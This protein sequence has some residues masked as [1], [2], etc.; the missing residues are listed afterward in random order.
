LKFK[1][2]AKRPGTSRREHDYNL[3]QAIGEYDYTLRAALANPAGQWFAAQIHTQ[4]AIVLDALGR[5]ADAAK[6]RELARATSR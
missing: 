3:A 6:D 4:K 1:Q 5:T 2:R